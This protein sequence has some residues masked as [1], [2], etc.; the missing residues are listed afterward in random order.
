[1]IRKQDQLKERVKELEKGLDEYYQNPN[2]S[3]DEAN[4][5]YFN[6]EKILRNE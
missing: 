1:L 2:P 4:E 5:M 6:T 3:E